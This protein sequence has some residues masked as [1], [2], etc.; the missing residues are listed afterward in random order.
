VVGPFGRLSD[1]VDAAQNEQLDG[2]LMD[3]NLAGERIFPAAEILAARAVPFLLLSGYGD[4]AL[5]DGRAHWPVQSK[6][7]EIGRVLEALSDMIGRVRMVAPAVEVL[8]GRKN[9]E[10]PVTKM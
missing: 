3:V 6:P 7:F 5:P 2:A 8:A 10:A 1:A 9:T 4:K